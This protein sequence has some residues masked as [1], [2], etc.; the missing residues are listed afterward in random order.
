MAAPHQAFSKC[1]NKIAPLAASVKRKPTASDSVQLLLDLKDSVGAFDNFAGALMVVTGP[2]G[3][4]IEQAFSW[5]MSLTNT[6]SSIM[7]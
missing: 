5:S 4:P 3:K 1:S 6:G 7:G 2:D